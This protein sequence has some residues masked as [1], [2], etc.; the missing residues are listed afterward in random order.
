MDVAGVPPVGPEGAITRWLRRAPPSAFSAY[1]IIAAFAT[2]F[3]MYAFR[4]PFTA[5]TFDGKL[6]LGPLGVLGLKSVFLI[7]QVFGYM[8]SKF[9]GIKLV[10]EMSGAR[11][12]IA[13]IILIGVA[14]GALALFA[15]TPAPW[16]ALWLFVNGLPLG[17]VWGLVF[18]FLEGRKTTEALGAGLSASFIVASGAM[19][20]IGS[21]VMGW[22]VSEYVM[23]VVVGAM[24]L[25]LFG[26]FVWM[27]TKL[28]RPSSEDEAL[29]TRREP[30]DGKARRA[31][32]M[33]F[34]PGLLPLTML[35]LVLTALRGVRDNFAPEI[36]KQ[37]GTTKPEILTLTEIP[38]ALGVMVG[39][40]L[41]MLVK[42]NRKALVT[43]QG[44]MGGG[45]AL[46]GIS[47]LL[48]DAGAISPTLWMI[49]IGLGLYLAYVPF[50]SMLFDRLI[51]A[52]GWVGTAGFM[53]YVTDAV[54]YLGEVSVYVYKELGAGDMRWLDFFRVLTYV[55]SA[56]CTAA[57]AWGMF[58]FGRRAR[59]R[60]A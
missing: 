56:V 39:L 38:V 36:W 46:V 11:R 7:T 15:V 45:A 1:A 24:F 22:G 57:F 14:E 43:V 27:L 8:L 33:A 31:F 35:H 17:M 47:T 54:G 25:P 44:L 41:L 9:V 16:N 28:P 55:T 29:R 49:L 2:Y 4:K 19:K 18:G 60:T 32:F 50:G 59:H 51:A 6:D 40:G 13:L 53:I 58:Y 21:M 34:L 42:N 52:M 10:S 23:P 5:G 48:F 12:G 30:M 20:T 26:F 3:C 37:L